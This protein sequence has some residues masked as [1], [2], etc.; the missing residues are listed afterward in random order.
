MPNQVERTAPSRIAALEAERGRLTKLIARLR[1][2]TPDQPAIGVE[3]VL[4]TDAADL[5]SRIEQ[6]LARVTDGT[7][8]TCT[9]CHQPVLEER[10]T[11][12]PYAEFCMPC[13]AKNDGFLR[14]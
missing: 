14:R 10:L 9:R 8:G 2:E 3:R 7:Y 13:V 5:L 12:I 6:A 1:L 4:S 11:A